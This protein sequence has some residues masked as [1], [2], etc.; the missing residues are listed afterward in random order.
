M[1]QLYNF[2]CPGCGYIAKMVSGGLGFG[3]ITVVR[4]MT[5]E[6]CKTVVDVVIERDGKDGSTGDPNYHYPSICRQCRGSRFYPWPSTH[7]CPKCDAKMIKNERP[8]LCWD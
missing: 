5:C 4:T 7:P 8:T 1:G 3:M 6:D 2:V